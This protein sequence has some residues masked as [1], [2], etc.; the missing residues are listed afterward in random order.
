MKIPKRDILTYLQRQHFKNKKWNLAKGGLYIRHC[1]AEKNQN[2]LSF[3]DDVGFVLNGRMV[4]VYWEHPRCAYYDAI[5]D[6]AFKEAGEAPISDWL[7][8]NSTTN[9]RKVGKSRKK[10]SGSTLHPFPEEH[11]AYCDNVQSIKKRLIK[12]GMDIEIRNA[13]NRNSSHWAIGV[14]LVAP[15]EVRNE[16]ELAQVALLVRKLILGKTTLDKEFPAYKYGKT[17]WLE[18]METFAQ[19]GQNII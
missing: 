13:Y 8:S 17:Q 9:Y 7:L 4:M 19:I 16:T 14:Y 10:A 18:D 11:R 12:Q 5:N 2:H 6:Q 15:L 3:W 1:Y